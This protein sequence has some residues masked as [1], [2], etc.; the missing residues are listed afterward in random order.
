MGLLGMTVYHAADS[1]GAST[2]LLVTMRPGEDASDVAAVKRIFNEAAYV[3]RYEF[4]DA[5]AVLASEAANMDEDGKKA[6]QLLSDNPYGDEFVVY[7][8]DGY[9]STDSLKVVSDRISGINGVDMV[10][11]NTD[12]MGGSNDG[13]R[14][15]MIYLGILALVLLVISIALIYTTISLAI[16]SRRFNIHTMKLVGATNSFIRRP[17]VRAGML[18]GALAGVIAAMVVSAIA[19]YVVSSEP[20][21]AP[22][23]TTT[24]IGIT[25]ASLIVLGAIITRVAAWWAASRYLNKTFD[26]LFK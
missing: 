13:L 25:A 19:A 6:L 1:V 5:A 12:V 11:G 4:K 23:V 22:Y 26:K 9:R 20:M 21:V 3:D 7:I 17:F 16:Y 24:D 14:T 15:I 18:T 10:T 2:Q 8:K